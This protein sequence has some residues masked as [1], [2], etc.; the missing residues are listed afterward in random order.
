MFV[1][2]KFCRLQL[3]SAKKKSTYLRHPDTH[4]SCLE[5]SRL[6]IFRSLSTLVVDGDHVQFVLLCVLLSFVTWV[7]WRAVLTCPNSWRPG[8]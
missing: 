2:N 6:H 1:F 8:T 3:R 5:K 7:G 4:P